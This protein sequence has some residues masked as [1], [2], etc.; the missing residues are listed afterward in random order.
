[1]NSTSE[2]VVGPSAAAVAD[3]RRLVQTTFAG[4][5]PSVTGDNLR[6]IVT[7]LLANALCTVTQRWC[8]GSAR[9]ASMPSSKSWTTVVSCRSTC[10]AVATR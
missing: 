4:V 5:D 1:M 9:K 3:A 6:L 10:G 7:E 8:C 2:V